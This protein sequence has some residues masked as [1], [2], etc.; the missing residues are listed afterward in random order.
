[1]MVYRR[2]LFP[3][4]Y[5]AYLPSVSIIFIIAW[6]EYLYGGKGYARGRLIEFTG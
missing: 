6:Q 4:S 2:I 3:A 5:R 1:M